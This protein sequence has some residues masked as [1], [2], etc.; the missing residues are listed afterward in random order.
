MS[1]S[2]SCSRL[3]LSLARL[4]ASRTALF[5]CHSKVSLP[6]SSLL[7]RLR[8]LTSKKPT[9]R[10]RPTPTSCDDLSSDASRLKHF[11]IDTCAQ[12]TTHAEYTSLTQCFHFT[13]TVF[14]DVCIVTVT[15]VNRTI[16]VCVIVSATGSEL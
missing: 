14:V 5:E 1:S 7:A 6:L 12:R 8:Q 11:S 2:I 10:Y 13:N 16:V 9:E 15:A 4:L 3:P